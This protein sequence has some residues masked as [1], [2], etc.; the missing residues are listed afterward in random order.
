[1]TADYQGNTRLKYVLLRK[2]YSMNFL[3]NF[4]TEEKNLGR[5]KLRNLK[6]IDFSFFFYIDL[7]FFIQTMIK[8]K[9]KSRIQFVKLPHNQT[10][11]IKLCNKLWIGLYL[12][13]CQHP[14][15]YSKSCFLIF[16][17]LKT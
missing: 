16:I 4:T 8:I 6:R 7:F 13:G 9:P 1:M 15:K 17:P 12:W 2:L 3:S 14:N 11:H 5:L 10:I